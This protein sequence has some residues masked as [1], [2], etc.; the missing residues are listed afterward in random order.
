M[1]S[2]DISISK[3]ETFQ[4]TIIWKT[5]APAT[6]VNLTGYRAL[7]QIRAYAEAPEALLTLTEEAGISLGGSTGQIVVTIT[8][9]QTAEL[10]P[11]AGVWDL[12]MLSG[13]GTAHFLVGGKA[14]ISQTVSR[15]E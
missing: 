2:R 3:G 6:P 13:G 5:G 15:E 10:I 1:I 11:L 7:L 8:D 9:E 14:T 4:L 12:K